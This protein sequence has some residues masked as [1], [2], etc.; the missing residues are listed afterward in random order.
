MN[1]TGASILVGVDHGLRLQGVAAL[2]MTTVRYL[3]W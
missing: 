2:G 3:P 1:A